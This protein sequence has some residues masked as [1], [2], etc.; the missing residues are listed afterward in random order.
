MSLSHCEIL[1][2]WSRGTILFG[3]DPREWRADEYSNLLRF[4]DLG[5]RSSRYGWEIDQ[6]PPGAIAG[7]EL[8]GKPRPL[9]WRLSADADEDAPAIAAPAALGTASGAVARVYR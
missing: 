2:I 1:D 6:A 4:Q 9:H 8:D 5:D 3:F 7:A